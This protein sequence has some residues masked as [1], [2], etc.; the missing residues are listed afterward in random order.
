MHRFRSGGNNV[1]KK[2]GSSFVLFLK[3]DSITN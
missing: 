1:V 2:Y 3:D